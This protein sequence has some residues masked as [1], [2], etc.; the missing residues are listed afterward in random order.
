MLELARP[1]LEEELARLTGDV[2]AHEVARVARSGRAWTD[3]ALDAL[4]LNTAEYLQEESRDLPARHEAE[5]FF[6]DVERIRDDVERA[7][8]RARRLGLGS[9]EAQEGPCDDSD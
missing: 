3:R 5:G 2:I 1:D 4:T 8:E 6:R 7:L 9:V